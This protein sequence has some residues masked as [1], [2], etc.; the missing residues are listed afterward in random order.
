M[1]QQFQVATT[2]QKMQTNNETRTDDLLKELASDYANY[3]V[4]D[5]STEVMNRF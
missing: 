3:M 4:V 2:D 1:S 5:S